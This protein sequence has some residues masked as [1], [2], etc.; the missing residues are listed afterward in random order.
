MLSLGNQKNSTFLSSQNR[1]PISASLL[2]AII[3]ILQ[4]STNSQQ[5]PRTNTSKYSQYPDIKPFV[6]YL[7]QKSHASLTT[8]IH[9]LVYIVRLTKSFPKNV[10]S[11]GN[12]I[13]KIFISALL[14]A[15]KFCNDLKP[16]YTK[17]IFY[18]TNNMFSIKEINRMERAFL[19]LLDYRL[20]IKQS[21]YQ[22]ILH[23]Y[24]LGLDSY[25]TDEIIY[26]F[27]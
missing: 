23:Q 27:F 10:L 13:Y 19:K 6:I 25:L 4:K 9:L 8:T 22:E 26:P 12:A 2:Q 20:Y 1:I 21:E 3:D 7:V 14:I 11:E 24:Q 5:L 15:C 16:L 17:K 18:L